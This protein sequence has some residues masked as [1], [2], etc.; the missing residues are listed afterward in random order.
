MRW[1]DGE[2]VSGISGGDMSEV[3]VGK[4]EVCGKDTGGKVCE[5]IICFDCYTSEDLETISK[6]N[7]LLKE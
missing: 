6:I 2:V 5:H 3:I 7:G 4:C 1:S